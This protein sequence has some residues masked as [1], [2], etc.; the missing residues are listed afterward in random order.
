MLAFRDNLKY[1]ATKRKSLI[2]RVPDIPPKIWRKKNKSRH[3]GATN[4]MPRG[5]HAAKGRNLCLKDQQFDITPPRNNRRSLPYTL[6]WPGKSKTDKPQQRYHKLDSAELLE[7]HQAYQTWTK[8]GKIKA[9]SPIHGLKKK[10][11]ACRH[12]S[13]FTRLATRSFEHGKISPVK[14]PGRPQTYDEDCDHIM[15]QVVDAKRAL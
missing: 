10:Y 3:T 14:S 6:P 7:C 12:K 8:G 4:K 5:K 1:K 9:D 2:L 11:P 15:K 13:F